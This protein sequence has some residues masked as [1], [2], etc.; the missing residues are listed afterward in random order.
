M[1][2]DKFYPGH[3]ALESLS[4]PYWYVKAL[5]DGRLGIVQQDSTTDYYDAASFRVYDYNTTSTNV[6]LSYCV[7]FVRKYKYMFYVFPK[8]RSTTQPRRLCFFLG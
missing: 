4:F 5:S 3:Y 7:H 2:S 1:H 8:S 6:L